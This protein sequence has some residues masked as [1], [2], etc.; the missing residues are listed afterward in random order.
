MNQGLKFE[1]R[2]SSEIEI[3]PEIIT[4]NERASIHETSWDTMERWDAKI[5]HNE[6]PHK[7][8]EDIQTGKKLM[9]SR[10]PWW[11]EGMHLELGINFFPQIHIKYRIHVNLLQQEC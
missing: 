4:L 6:H 2:P 11:M 8:D 9:G 10:G 5:H 1:S 7:S 3:N